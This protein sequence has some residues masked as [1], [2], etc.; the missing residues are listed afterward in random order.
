[1]EGKLPMGYYIDLEAVSLERYKQTLKA[2][3]LA[4]SRQMIRE[5]IDERFAL[6]ESR[7][8]TN[9]QQ[10]LGALKTKAKVKQMAESSGIPEAYLTM[11]SRE[12]RSH[13]KKPIKLKEFS[14][15]SEETAQKLEAMGMGSTVAL[16]EKVLT[17]ESRKQLVQLSGISE[18]E[19]LTIAKLVDLSRI[20]WVNHTFAQVLLAVGYGSAKQVAEADYNKMFET[21][22]AM[23]EDK[24]LF[25]GSVG[26]SDIKLCVEVA[27]KLSKELEL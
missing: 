22:K 19:I 6:I 3:Y 1:M 17:Q 16:Y 13:I 14:L 27:A 11:V 10:L 20:R 8:I 5:E 25:K 7:G 15:I 18:D 21:I 9:A 12:I 23:N 2:E 24:Q 4:P 26:R